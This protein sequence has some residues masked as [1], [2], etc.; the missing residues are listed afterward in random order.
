MSYIQIGLKHQNVQLLVVEVF[1]K[2]NVLVTTQH[3]Y[4]EANL[5]REIK[6]RNRN[7]MNEQ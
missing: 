7:V 5:V 6:H 3:H 4:M 2:W 1:R